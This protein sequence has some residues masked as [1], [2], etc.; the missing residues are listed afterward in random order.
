MVARHARRRRAPGAG[1]TSATA[2][3]ETHSPPR[4]THFGILVAIVAV[5]V[6]YSGAISAPFQFDDIGS[7]VANRTIDRLWPPSGPLHPPPGVAVSGRPVVNYSLAV[8]HAV[9]AAL[10]IDQR[11]D[12]NGEHKTVS[13]HVTNLLL[14]VVCGLLLFGVLRRALSSP[15]L[16]AEWRS[17]AEATASVVALVWVL[18]PIQ[19]EV[20]DYVIQR[21]ESLVS[22]CYLATL[23]ASI[24][25]WDARD[26]RRTVMW[27]CVAVLTCTLGM[28]SKEV[29]ITA[30]IVVILYD[31]ALRVTSWR[32]LLDR[33]GG[34]PWLYLAL[35]A[36]TTISALLIVRGA[37]SATVGFNLGVT[38]YQYLYS[39]GWAIGRY[40]RLALWPDQ[41][42]Y[43]Y[44]R[45]PITGIRG[46][47]GS[48]AIIGLAVATVIAWFRSPPLG[49]AGL[50]F[51]LLL[52]PS[53]SFVPIRTEIAAER[54]IYLAL[55]SVIAVLAIAIDAAHR[56]AAS[57]SPE[58]RRRWRWRIG[59]AVGVAYVLLCGVA[60]SRLAQSVVGENG[61]VIAEWLIRILIGT[62]A[63]IVVSQ[64]VFSRR[65]RATVGVLLVLL[66]VATYVRGRTYDDPEK[67]WRGSVANVPSNAR[68][69]D[70]L[71]AV[72]LRDSPPRTAEA[73]GL[74]RHA[75]SVDSMYLPAWR[76][77]A[78]ILAEQGRL[79]EAE[80][81]LKRLVAIDSTYVD[82]LERLGSVLV[83]MGRADRALPYL[84]RAAAGPPSAENFVSLGTAY[85]SLG[86]S[87]D[88]VSAFRRALQIDTTRTDAMVF[89]GNVLMEQ[90]RAADAIAPLEAA[91]HRQPEVAYGAA[92]LAL[93]YAQ[94]NREADAIAAA[95]SAVARANDDPSVLL[96]VGRALLQVNRAADA[97]RFFAETVRLAPSDPEAI[98]RYGMAELQ[99]GKRAEA[100]QL[101][102]RA[103]AVRPDYIPAKHGLDLL[104][105]K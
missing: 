73:E 18:H 21:T 86:R 85:A 67:L 82:A 40:L 9:N 38:W 25:A 69:Y 31:R 26:Q 105:P 44:G 1:A 60:A 65:R 11:P 78:T 54:R 83:A 5:I 100:E 70:N 68:A 39:Q 61:G 103:L 46:V 48:V 90:G 37:R 57:I 58:Q 17:S 3:L 36:A 42:T 98:T 99:L 81:L 76:N 33:R 74:L 32:S 94:L 19:T 47:P 75:I 41:L 15:A 55:A 80:A 6:A 95:N 59:V 23:Y 43:D 62:V 53:S 7:I 49:F 35:I 56:R 8:D 88:A 72:V 64:L 77:L 97:E 22:A 50:W 101:F 12:P 20:V 63:A 52:A 45:D 96:L 87:D 51:F 93:A 10:D 34:R 14:H 29:M 28:A 4:F 91:V 102:R 24:R 89:L 104:R 84:E 79:P 13:F 92:V 71:A 16:K 30:P 66:G 27:C 2:V